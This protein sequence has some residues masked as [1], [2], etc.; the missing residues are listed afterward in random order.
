MA[1]LLDSN[2]FIHAKNLY[3]GFDVCPGFWDWLEIAAENDQVRSI[4]SVYDELAPGGDD[5]AQWV[6]DHRA[7]FLPSDAS[8]LTEL[9]TVNQWAQTETRYTPG[10][11]TQFAGNADSRLVAFGLAQGHTIVTHE[12]P[13]MNKKNV[14]KIP[15][16]AAAHSIKCVQ[17]HNVLRTL[18]AT[19]VLPSG[20]K[21]QM[22]LL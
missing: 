8:V 21:A 4:D 18:G 15:D 1:Y 3:Y 6:R 20:Q 2:C 13:G 7:M 10:A 12:L 11:K 22:R 9:G 16:A 17:L 5:L 19:F 14:I